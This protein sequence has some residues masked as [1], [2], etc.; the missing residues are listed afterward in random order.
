MSLQRGINLKALAE[1]MGQC[2]GAEVRG[3][4]TEAG[5]H[6]II[7]AHG[8]VLDNLPRYVR[9]TRKKTARHT[10]RLRVCYC[11]GKACFPI[12]C[13][14]YRSPWCSRCSRSNKKQIPR[15]ISS[16]PDSQKGL[17]TIIHVTYNHWRVVITFIK[18]Q[19]IILIQAFILDSSSPLV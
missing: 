12:C 9:I 17:Y 19:L 16:S 13:F 8:I 6:M 3:I 15:S 5:T 2:S 10:G 7:P 11:E 18:K 14:L 4:C 1:K